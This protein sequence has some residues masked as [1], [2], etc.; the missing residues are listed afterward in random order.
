MKSI[1][2]RERLICALDVPD[3]AA[4]RRMV[5][6]LGDTVTFYKLGLELMTAGGYHELLDWLIGRG[7]KV[8]ADLK[9]FDIPATVA[10][11]VRGL[12]GRGVTYQS[13]PARGYFSACAAA[14]SPSSSARSRN[15]L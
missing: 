3:A 6:T 15:C 4:A 5:E 1:P 14:A 11:A 8:F 2:P 9:F 13:M 10:G 12:N 7:N